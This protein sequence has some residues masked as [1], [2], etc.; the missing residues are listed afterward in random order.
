MPVPNQRSKKNRFLLASLLLSS[1]VAVWPREAC[2]Q[3]VR[4]QITIKD[5]ATEAPIAGAKVTMSYK[6]TNYSDTRASNKKGL[7][8]FT[9]RDGPVEYDVAI[10]AEGYNPATSKL[11]PV[12]GQVV[13]Q[14]FHIDPV[15]GAAAA[16]KA[17]ETGKLTPAQ[18]TF[19][20][21][22]LALQSGEL[23]AA[24]GKFEEALRLDPTLLPAESALAGVYLET[25]DYA[26]AEASARKVATADPRNPRGQRLLYDALRGQGKTDAAQEVF[27]V[28]KG[29][30]EGGDLTA[31]VYNEGTEALRLGDTKTARARF[32]QALQLNP[33]L[34]QARGAL[35]VI[36]INAKEYALAVAAAEKILEKRPNDINAK[37]IRYDGYRRLDDKA[38]AKEAFDALAAADPKVLIKGLFDEAQA[39]F[40]NGDTAGA[41]AALDEILT[42]DPE[43]AK[44]YYLR[45]LCFTN[46]GK[47]ADAKAS[48][49]KFIALAPTDPMAKTAKEMIGFLK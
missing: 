30:E 36:Y 47:N 9:L 29:L 5:A 18:E 32:E 40:N 22:V 49:E 4:A 48:L 45:G 42:I 24:Q 2:A 20:E 41:M 46:L 7:A 33:D 37:R 13:N 31:L 27:E 12:L 44:T 21:G 10:E 19:N 39:A 14:T 35:M 43:H 28:L 17:D 16:P 3:V 8:T 26:A 6:S 1:L 38:K 23:A 15:G 11:R 34:D 25:K